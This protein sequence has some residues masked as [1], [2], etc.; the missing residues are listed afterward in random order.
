MFTRFI[1]Q[2]KSKLLDYILEAL[3]FCSIIMHVFE[4]SS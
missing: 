2:V 1:K 4:T 3:L